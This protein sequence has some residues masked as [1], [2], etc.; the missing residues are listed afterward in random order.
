MG[1]NQISR[2]IFRCDYCGEWSTQKPSAY[3]RK[4]RHFCC[5]ACYSGYRRDILPTIEQHAYR[6]GGMPIQEKQKRIK[7]RSDL[8]HAVKQ[9]KVKK[10]SCQKCGSKYSQAHHPNYNNPLN[11]Q[12]L[13]QSCHWNLHS[14]IHEN[15]ELLEAK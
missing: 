14:R 3:K 8:N 15:P 13:C 1:N 2:I 4:I 12:W 11:V 9:G 5:Q 7:A 6:N 10:V